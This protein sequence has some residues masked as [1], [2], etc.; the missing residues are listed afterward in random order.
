MYQTGH[1]GL[2]LLC[3]TPLGTVLVA[4]GRVG[5]AITTGLLCL[6]LAT[7]PDV[8]LSVSV[9]R[10]RGPTHS[11]TFALVVAVAVGA[12][13][14]NLDAL[15]DYLLA[16]LRAVP[17]PAVAWRLGSDLV[18]LLPEQV[19]SG[20]AYPSLRVSGAVL[21]LAAGISVLSHVLG[22]ALTPAGVE[23]LWP[24]SRERFSVD[25]VLAENDVA[26]HAL[27]VAGVVS[28]GLLFYGVPA[29]PVADLP[30]LGGVSVW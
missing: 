22:D 12:L 18:G 7:L 8:D 3:W 9:L 10:H 30:W 6:W 16:L 11:V 28:L 5:L 24:V 13:V 19:R 20:E 21:G 15:L 29:I 2:A 14:A 26:N 23:L 17:I 27:L 25:L 4:R 1:V